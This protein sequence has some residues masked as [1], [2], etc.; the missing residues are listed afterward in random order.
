VP[1]PELARERANLTLSALDELARSRG[2][3]EPTSELLAAMAAIELKEEVL[4]VGYDEVSAL[5]ERL[6]RTTTA[7]SAYVPD[8]LDCDILFYEAAD[9]ARPWNLVST[10]QPVVRSID[11]RLIPGQHVAPL[12]EPH[13]HSVAREIAEMIERSR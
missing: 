10:W 11:H 12:A 9:V 5:M 1:Q 13:V 8:H 4:T 3:A 2:L 7:L 6:L